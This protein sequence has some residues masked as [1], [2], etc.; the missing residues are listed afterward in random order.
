MKVYSYIRR[1]KE[2]NSEK[3]LE[4][5]RYKIKQYTDAHDYR[6]ERE[7][8]DLVSGGTLLT[9]RREGLELS[10]ILQKGDII[11]VSELSRYSRNHFGLI[12]D[13]EKYRRMKVKLIFTDLGDVVST[14]SL[15]SIFYQIL[16]IMSEWYRK[17]LSEKQLLAKEK[18]RSQGKYLGGRV[19]KGKDIGENNVLVDCEKELKEIRMIMMFRNQGMKYKDIKFEMERYTG[20]KQH[21]SFLHK[22]VQRGTGLKVYD[23]VS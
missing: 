4:L 15:G 18:L 9:Q 5:Q 1:S 2:E 3:S 19:S 13:V 12:S 20:K 10:S 8:V 6:I 7:F 22:I 16:S 21:I 14:D 23:A 17:S 11:I